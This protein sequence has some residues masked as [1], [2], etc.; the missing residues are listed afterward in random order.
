MKLRNITSVHKKYRSTDKE[1]YRPVSV[2][3]LLS[4]IFGRLIYD[5][6]SEYLEHYLSSLLCGFRKAHST[7]QKYVICMILKL[8]QE[9]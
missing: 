6:L 5:Q 9:W 7:Q 2:L 3:S 8:L 4:E 1:N